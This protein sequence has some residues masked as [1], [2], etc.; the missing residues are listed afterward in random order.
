[1]VYYIIAVVLALADQG[2]KKWAVAKL[3]GHPPMVII[4]K[5]LDLVYVENRG[6]AFGILENQRWIFIVITVAVICFLIYYIANHHK[7]HSPLVNASL[8]L[9]LAG[10]VGN[11]IDRVIQGYVV[12]FIFVK[13]GGLY[14]FPVFNLADVCVVVGWGL[15]MIALMATKEFDSKE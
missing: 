7:T 11:L 6:A 3:K 8:T 10:A 4:D 1:M 15:L 9:I 14:D 2:L 5:H 12:D 13:F